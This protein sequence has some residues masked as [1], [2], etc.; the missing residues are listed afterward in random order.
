MDAGMLVS[1]GISRAG[2]MDVTVASATASVGSGELVRRVFDVDVR[3]PVDADAEL[4]C[5]SIDTS[6]PADIVPDAP[7][8]DGTLSILSW[9]G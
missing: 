5:T 2:Y 7:C 3:A 4:L 6:G 1:S 9:R 8:S